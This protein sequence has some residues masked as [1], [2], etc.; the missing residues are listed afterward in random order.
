MA[1]QTPLRQSVCVKDI[2]QSVRNISIRGK[3][4]GLNIC[5]NHEEERASPSTGVSPNQITAPILRPPARH[6]GVLKFD[7]S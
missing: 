1:K 7:K 4:D 5:L 6:S 3:E 2:I